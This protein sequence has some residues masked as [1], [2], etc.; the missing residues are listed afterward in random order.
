MTSEQ[1]TQISRSFSSVNVQPLTNVEFSVSVGSTVPTSVTTLYDCPETVRS[2]LTGLPE[3]K[4]IVV[5]DQVVILEPRTRRI[6]TVIER[7]G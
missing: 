5:R 7:R 6:V 3:C 2:I 4:Y 1:R